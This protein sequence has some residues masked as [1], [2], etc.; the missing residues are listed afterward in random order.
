MIQFLNLALDLYEKCLQS[1]FIEF[2]GIVGQYFQKMFVRVTKLIRKKQSNLLQT[3]LQMY[4]ERE[5]QK[6]D[7]SANSNQNEPLFYDIEN[8]KTL[9]T[10]QP[11]LC[12]VAIRISNLLQRSRMLQELLS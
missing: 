9:N 10:L 3:F 6:Q 2:C 11:L 4:D 8:L 12:Q 7:A 1:Q 5:Q